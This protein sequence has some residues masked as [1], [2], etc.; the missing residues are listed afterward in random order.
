MQL[1]QLRFRS[2][3]TNDFNPRPVFRNRFT[4]QKHTEH[5]AGFCRIHRLERELQLFLVSVRRPLAVAHHV[6]PRLLNLVHT[7]P[8]TVFEVVVGRFF[9]NPQSRIHHFLGLGF[10][11]RN[12]PQGSQAHTRVIISHALGQARRCSIKALVPL[13]KH[14]N[15]CSANPAIFG[16][17]QLVE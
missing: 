15:R 6:Q 1:L 10:A 4:F 12:G 2:G 7:E 9:K 17:E 14:L 11:I 16:L 13:V 5:F 3:T 8:G